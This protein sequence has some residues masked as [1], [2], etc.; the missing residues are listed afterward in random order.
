MTCGASKCLGRNA[1]AMRSSPWL[2][3]SFCDY[4]CLYK[5]HSHFSVFW[6]SFLSP[7]RFGSFSSFPMPRICFLRCWVNGKEWAT[8]LGFEVAILLLRER[9]GL[10]HIFVNFPHSLQAGKSGLLLLCKWSKEIHIL[11][12][13][14]RL[15]GYCGAIYGF[16]KSDL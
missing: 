12:V 8:I 15:F 11:W 1:Q 14:E 10:P 9:W 6:G 2:G 4:E 5:R 13:W 7:S 16:L 3:K